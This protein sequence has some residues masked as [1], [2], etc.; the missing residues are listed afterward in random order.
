[1]SELQP[2]SNDNRPDIAS[3]VWATWLSGQ[4][5]NQQLHA[6]A[7]HEALDIPE[8]PTGVNSTKFVNSGFGP[9]GALGIGLL[10]LL[11][12]SLALFSQ[13]ALD[14]QQSSGPLPPAAAESPSRDYEVRFFDSDGNVIDVPW[15]PP[16]EAE[17]SGPPVKAN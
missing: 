13:R 3:S 1:M 15:S 6:R 8:N 11:G 14:P 2:S 12:A 9:L 16:T 10:P 17:G 5:A 4:R 7:V